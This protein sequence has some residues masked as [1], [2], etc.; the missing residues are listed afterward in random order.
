MR[1]RRQGLRI[2][3]IKYCPANGAGVKALDQGLVVNPSSTANIDETRTGLVLGMPNMSIQQEKTYL[4]PNDSS[5]A[6]S[7]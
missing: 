1:F 2:E 4:T 3:D 5:R 7:S 6:F